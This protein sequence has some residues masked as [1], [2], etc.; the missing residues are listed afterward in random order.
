[1]EIRI[2]GR[3]CEN[4]KTPSALQGE[5][6]QKKLPCP[7]ASS[8]PSRLQN[9]RKQISGFKSPNQWR[10]VSAAL[11]T[12]TARKHL[13]ILESPLTWRYHFQAP[14]LGKLVHRDRETLQRCLIELF[15]TDK[16]QEQTV[17]Q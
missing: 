11:A 15:T 10:F 1:M 7:T 5:R 4:K 17:A 14:A 6:R 3:L 16:K 8:Q 9:L 2:E 12:H 13:N